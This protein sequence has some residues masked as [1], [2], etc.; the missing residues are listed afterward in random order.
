MTPAGRELNQV[1]LY[2]SFFRS[3][4]TPVRR[5]AGGFVTTFDVFVLVVTLAAALG[6]GLIAGVF[7]AFSSFVMKALAR[8]PP[9]EG[10]AAMQ[11]INIVVLRSW[12]MAVFLGTAAACFTTLVCSLLWWNEPGALYLLIGSLLNLVGGFLVTVLFNV[13]RNE[14]LAAVA[15]ADPNGASLWARYVVTWTAWNHVRT[16]ASLAAMVAFTIAAAHS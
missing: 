9:G 4:F 5:Q 8:R 7:F 14:A 12:F 3:P 10:M 15:P 2:P 13:P 11:S 6:C 1:I 16:V